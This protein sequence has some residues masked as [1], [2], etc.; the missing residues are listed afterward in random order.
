MKDTTALTSIV[1]SHK[2]VG[3]SFRS[4][5]TYKREGITWRQSTSQ[6]KLIIIKRAGS[7]SFST[8]RKEYTYEST[9][10]EIFLFV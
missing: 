5:T 7:N 6:G 9:I 1:S 10:L 8:S 3:W 2:Q 4:R